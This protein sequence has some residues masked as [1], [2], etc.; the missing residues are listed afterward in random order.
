M[1]NMHA[2]P[3]RT[4]PGFWT[5]LALAVEAVG[6][7]DAERLEK[8]IRRLEAEVERLSTVQEKLAKA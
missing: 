4:V 5:R 1:N 6:E 3:P 2:N 7:S 8:R